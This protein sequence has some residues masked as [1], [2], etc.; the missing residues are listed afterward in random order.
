MTIAYRGYSEGTPGSILGGS[1]TLSVIN[2]AGMVAGDQIILVM[3]TMY[4][5]SITPPAGWMAVRT[6]FG[7]SVGITIYTAVASANEPA[8]WPF[9]LTGSIYNGVQAAPQVD[10]WVCLAYSGGATAN[11]VIDVSTVTASHSGPNLD[12]AIVSLTAAKANSKLVA[13]LIYPA[14][15]TAM[16]EYA[17]PSGMTE[18]LESSNALV[19]DEARSAAGATGSRTFVRSITGEALTPTG[20]GFILLPPPPPTIT[21]VVPAFG[22]I[23]GG[24]SVVITGTGFASGA[25]VTIKGVAATD[26]MVVSDTIITCTTG[27]ATAGR[28]DVVV[29]SNGETGTATNGYTY[30]D[31]ADNVVK[32]VKGG[33]VVGNNNASASQ[34]PSGDAPAT[35]G[36]AADLWG[37]T[38]SPSD[39]NA[40]NF[41]VVL[42][43]TVNAGQARV[44]A[45]RVRIHY[46]VPGVSDPATYLAVLRVASD[47][48]TA[49]PEIYRLPR[50]GLTIG[51]DPNVVHA[52]DSAVLR[53]SRYVRP[54]RILEKTWRV[55][56]QWID[57][58]PEA[59][60][61]GLQ[62]FLKVD[63]GAEVQ[64]VDDDGAPATLRTS[65]RHRVFLPYDTR[66]HYAQLVYRVP[67]AT[68]GQADVAVRLGEGVLRGTYRPFGA[69][70]IKAVFICGR[71]E[72][73]SRASMRAT[74]PTQRER[75][76]A[77]AG[78]V[79]P[80]RSP[81]GE[82][83]Y[84]Q[85]ESVSVR[86]HQFRTH[87]GS[88]WVATMQM[89]TE[90]YA[91]E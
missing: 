17:P 2:P 83:G 49:R 61:P 15:G 4:V 20:F 11:P 7:N 55:L 67:E 46:T 58:S 90:P 31:V 28:G 64:F 80:Y 57:A 5:A 69:R 53:T 18:R 59:N 24:T 43:A 70:R 65:G 48:Q 9:R 88:S 26:V 25:S 52:R 32:L 54:A 77:L 71:G 68:L 3:R 21:T 84:L 74:S 27:A 66:G 8:S 23:S 56:D 16:T 78:K 12:V 50:A 85:V 19:D 73:E 40:S 86:E 63:E 39:V 60:T 10:A 75:L 87:E 14:A 35:Y 45:V 62:I 89:R 34:W 30:Y 38:L 29:T 22:G 47:R 42:S 76:E 36:G 13:G 33:S 81:W 72:L 41:G 51:H 44:D 79:I 91:A 82:E 1:P 37:T 6:A